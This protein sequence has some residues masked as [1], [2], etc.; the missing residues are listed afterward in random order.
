MK[1]IFFGHYWFCLLTFLC[2]NSATV[3]NNQSTS[4]NQNIAQN[5]NK[6]VI[7]VSSLHS[8]TA[9]DTTIKNNST[10]LKQPSPIKKVLGYGAV[11]AYKLLLQTT[12]NYLMPNPFFKS[13]A[14]QNSAETVISP[15]V[16]YGF[17]YIIHKKPLTSSAK[18]LFKPSLRICCNELLE[19]G[20]KRVVTSLLTYCLLHYVH[21]KDYFYYMIKPFTATNMV[22]LDILPVVLHHS[23]AGLAQKYPQIPQ[24]LDEKVRNT[25]NNVLTSLVKLVNGTIKNTHTYLGTSPEEHALS[26]PIN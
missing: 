4:T 23:F 17:D 20:S 16:T 22:Q 9:Q 21:Q 8:T 14:L 25:T 19:N 18:I 6:V 3:T 26:K 15:L 11:I 2:F 5:N 1:K 12:N 13:C 24:W 7:D 10:R